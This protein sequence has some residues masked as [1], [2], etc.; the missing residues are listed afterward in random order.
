MRIL[1]FVSVCAL[2]LLLAINSVAATTF[3]E[4]VSQRQS[5]RSYADA[6]ITSEQL[7]SVLSA[8]YGYIGVDR[9][10]PRI[11]LDYSLAVYVVNSTASYLYNPKGNALSLHNPSVNKKTNPPLLSWA[12]DA[13]AYLVI[14][15]NQTRMGNE[16]LAFIEAGCLVQNVYLAAADQNL[17]TCCIGAGTEINLPPNLTEI[18]TMPLGYPSFGYPNATPAYERMNG[19]LP[20]VQ[21]NSQSLT[22]ALENIQYVQAWSEQ[23]LSTQD[24]SQLLWAAYGYSSTGHRTTPSAEG[25]YPLVV[26]VSNSTGVYQYIAENHSVMLVQFGDKRSEIATACGNQLWAASAPAI[27]LVAFNSSYNADK[28]LLQYYAEVDAGCVAQ[29]I[30]L[31]ASAANLLANPV[32]NGLETWNGNGAQSLRSILNLTPDVVFL[33]IVPV[34]YHATVA[35]PSPTATASSS[36]SASP[37]STPS[38]SPSASPLSTPPP[39]STP[40]PTPT[41]DFPSFLVIGLVLVCALSILVL[42]KLARKRKWSFLP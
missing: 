40:T 39:T 8:A 34:G 9:V 33:F 11:G 17:G 25:V 29:Q 21:I 2:C 10:V 1:W 38:A 24:I 32:A 13:S 7:M 14:V 22:D 37:S 36:P 31:E 6:D 26:Y 23:S 5:V 28:G 20:L 3:E 16:H 12:S 30:L 27:F 41:T 35:T 42:L 18:L 15:W 19:N 4:I